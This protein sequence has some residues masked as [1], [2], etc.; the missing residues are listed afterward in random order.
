M[1]EALTPFPNFSNGPQR[2]VPSATLAR[3]RVAPPTPELAIKDRHLDA[4]LGY[5]NIN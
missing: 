5:L 2:K 1:S 4:E 3:S